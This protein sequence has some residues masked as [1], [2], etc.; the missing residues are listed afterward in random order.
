MVVQIG[1]S[2]YLVLRILSLYRFLSFYIIISE[3]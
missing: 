2:Q 3:S 1:I